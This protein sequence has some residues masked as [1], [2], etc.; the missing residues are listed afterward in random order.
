M[1]D[2]LFRGTLADLDHEVHQLT[3]FEIRTTNTQT[4]SYSSESTALG[5]TRSPFIFISKYYAEGYRMKKA[6]DDRR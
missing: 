5:C 3:Q 6:L 4:H 1:S 2:F